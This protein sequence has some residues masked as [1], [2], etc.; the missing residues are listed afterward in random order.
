M[1]PQILLIRTVRH[2]RSLRFGGLVYSDK[3]P[4]LMAAFSQASLLQY[5]CSFCKIAM[6][7]WPRALTS[8]TAR[9]TICILWIG[10]RSHAHFISYS[11]ANT[12]EIAK[13][14]LW[15]KASHALQLWFPRGITPAFISFLNNFLHDWRTMYKVN[16]IFLFLFQILKEAAKDMYA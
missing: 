10:A 11:S 12:D 1:L 7:V 9:W 13:W 2:T 15:Q 6:Q 4:L 3:R 5:K 8:A 14:F 16:N